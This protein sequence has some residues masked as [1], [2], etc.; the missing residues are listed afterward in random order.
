MSA[1]DTSTS[2]KAILE[3]ASAVVTYKDAQ[4]VNAMIAKAVGAEYRRPLGNTW[5]NFGMVSQAGDFDHKV[6]EAVTNAQDAVIERAARERWGEAEIPYTSPRAAAS[7]LLDLAARDTHK[8]I[9]VDIRDPGRA[10]YVSLSVSDDGCGMTAAQMNETVL[11]LGSP[12]K[13]DSLHL[14]G[15]FGLGVKSTFRNA[16]AAVIISRRAPEMGD[17]DDE[18]S[19][20]VVEWAE[21]GQKGLGA[22]YLT[23]TDWRDGQD[24]SARP[25]SASADGLD[26]EA[27]TQLI[28]VEYQ[29]KGLHRAHS[30]DT[31]SF[32]TMADTRLHEPVIP[33]R[34]ISQFN[35]KPEPR[36]VYGLSRSL[37]DKV[38][39]KAS[40]LRHGRDR[41]PF[42][43]DGTTYQLPIDWWVFPAAKGASGGRDKS[44]NVGHVVSFTSSGQIHHHWDQ[45]KFRAMSGFNKIPDRVYVVVETDELP[46]K[47]RTRLFTPDRAALLPNDDALRLEESLAGF[48]KE[49]DDLRE[50]NGELQREAVASALGARKTRAVADLISQTFHARGF[51]TGAAAALGTG[52]T[53]RTPPSGK[54]KKVKLLKEPTELTGPKRLTVRPEETRTVT[55]YLDAKDS[56]AKRGGRLE[57]ECDHPSISA[58]ELAVGDLRDGRVR[59]NLLVPE[60]AVT[61]EFTLSAAV[62]EWTSASGGLGGP[63]SWETT[64]VVTTDPPPPR[65]PQKPG[66]ATGAGATVALQW[67]DQA[68]NVAGFIEEIEAQ[69]LATDEEYKDLA[70]LGDQQITTIVLNEQYAELKRYMDVMRKRKGEDRVEMARGRYATAIGVGLLVLNADEA[71]KDLEPEQ[72]AAA[73]RAQARTALSLLPEFEI[74]LTGLEED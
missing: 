47:T 72:L 65:S 66:G 16:Q 31:R 20:A 58:Q 13:S 35:A 45:P 59:V 3:A 56:F 46:I 2:A 71:A 44:V 43:I 69:N 61:G 32:G 1:T 19:I 34:Y 25:W 54:K 23:T 39:D 6:I 28:L 74:L 50:I 24:L 8:R 9:E 53:S 5:N 52:Q 70:S 63:L 51:Q 36:T 29:V 18:V 37:G 57:V 62:P 22:Y 40:K 11:R 41:L 42:A 33:F 12:H 38:D 4:A 15:A 55:F 10:K 14:Q 60:D 17:A 27:G 30:G 67:R 21:Y 68:G 7:D 64:L 26:F 48:L 73:A 49:H